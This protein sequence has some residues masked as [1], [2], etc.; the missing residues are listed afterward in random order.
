MQIFEKRLSAKKASTL[1]VKNKEKYQTELPRDPASCNRVILQTAMLRMAWEGASEK[2]ARREA[3][4]S[5]RNL[6]P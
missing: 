4:K 6:L 1:C 3:G 5:N 2:E